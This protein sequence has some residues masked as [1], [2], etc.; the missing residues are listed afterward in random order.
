[1]RNYPKSIPST[2]SSGQPSSSWTT[3]LPLTKPPLLPKPKQS[4]PIKKLNL[5]EMQ[6][7]HD[8]GQQ[9]FLAIK[10]I[11]GVTSV[12]AEFLLFIYQDEDAD[13]VSWDRSEAPHSLPSSSL[14]LDSHILISSN[15]TNKNP[16]ISF[17]AMWDNKS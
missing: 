8:K 5:A 17:H 16:H 9:L 7:Q 2:F 11:F 15:C 10:S 12:K 13:L 14:Q 6:E 1:M 4:V 3:T